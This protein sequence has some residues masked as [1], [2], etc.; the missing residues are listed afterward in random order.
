MARMVIAIWYWLAI[1]AGV[2]AAV[3]GVISAGQSQVAVAIGVAG[4]VV[5]VVLARLVREVLSAG[6]DAV[7]LLWEARRGRGG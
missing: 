6:L 2:G 5:A 7:D 1:L 4:G 3:L